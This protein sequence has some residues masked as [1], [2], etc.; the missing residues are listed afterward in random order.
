M[1]HIWVNKHPQ[2]FPQGGLSYQGLTVGRYSINENICDYGHI[3]IGTTKNWELP[4]N[5]VWEYVG[6]ATSRRCN[7]IQ[8]KLNRNRH[9]A[10]AH[11]MFHYRAI[12][13]DDNSEGTH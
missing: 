8:L 5:D 7:D 9:C 11:K 1:S 4:Q 6:Q 10:P 3:Y 13:Q 12:E 2:L